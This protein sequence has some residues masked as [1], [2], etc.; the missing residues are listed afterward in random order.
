MY[1]P[2]CSHQLTSD[3]LRFCPSCGF[4]L[5][6][7]TELLRNDG[8]A[9]REETPPPPR[10]SLFKWGT[11]LGITLM[12]ISAL[13]ITLDIPRGPYRGESMAFLTLFWAALVI[14]I[15]L[16]GPLKSAI[17]KA[18]AKGKTQVPMKHITALP[19]AEGVPI[20][21]TGWQRQKTAPIAPP[22]S[23]TEA[24]TSLLDNK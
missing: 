15:S 19:S 23:V 10:T 4:R 11:L 12:Y 18:F 6:A 8:I 17:D 13:L 2:Q 21:G 24:T 14:L 20:T 3:A 1:C 16:A 5:D 22:P 7:V 9:P